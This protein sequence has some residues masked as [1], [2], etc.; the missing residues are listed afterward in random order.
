MATRRK[1]SFTTR[2]VLLFGILL[3][4][5]NTALGLVSFNQSKSAMRALIE[6]NML[7]IVNSAA[8]SLDGDV[9]GALTADDVGGPEFEEIARRLTVFKDSTDIEYIYAVRRIAQDQ[10]VFTVDPDPV[11]PGEFGEEVVVTAALVRACDGEPAVDSTPAADEWG[12][13]YSAYSP[14]RD[15]SGNVVGAVGVDFSTVWFEEQIAANTRSIA[16]IIALSVVLVGIVVAIISRRTRMKFAALN[17]GL[18]ELSNDVDVL[19]DQMVAYS[20]FAVPETDAQHAYTTEASDE[21]E[22]LGG[23]IHTIQSEMRLYLDYLHT[24][25]YT[26]ALTKVN[27]SLAYHEVVE[28]LEKQIAEGRARFHVGIFDINSLKEINDTYGHACGD[29]Y[30]QGAAQALMRS[31]GDKARVY[32]VGG[33][34]FCAIYCEMDEAAVQESLAAVDTAVD[35]FNASSDYP[36][37]LAISKGVSGYVP[38]ED[39][40]FKDVFGRADQAMYQDKREYYRRMGEQDRR[41]R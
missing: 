14:V 35:E 24:Q 30:I 34:E 21:I 41:R 18:S 27:N 33:D 15:S 8:A 36:A 19:M 32:R 37:T 11:D 39:T 1:L 6:K 13:F 16:F 29:Y 22:E 17:Q 38:G 26:D 7:D 3:L 31:L 2:Y 9:L 5:A 10:Y 40:A 23:K 4:I 28:E 20:G 25:A 12:N